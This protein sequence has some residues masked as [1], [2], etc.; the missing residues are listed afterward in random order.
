MTAAVQDDVS[1]ER[2][3]ALVAA[4]CT[5]DPTLSGVGAGLLVAHFLGVTR[6]SRSFS[7]IFG[8]AHALVLREVTALTGAPGL[9]TVVSR[10]DRTQRTEL[11]LTPKGETLVSDALAKQGV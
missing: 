6:D 5:A 4:V 9:M 1:E 3:L 11:A 2:F 7:R 8:V 10:N